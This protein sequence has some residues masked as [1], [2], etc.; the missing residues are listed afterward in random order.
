[1]KGSGA[2]RYSWSPAYNISSTTDPNVTLNPFHTTQYILTGYNSRNCYSTDTLN[3]LV[4]EDCGEMYV[5]NAFSPN[6]DGANDVLYVR[7]LCL[8]SLS[9][10]IFNRWGEK[11]F[12]TTD[13]KVG[14]DGTY[15]GEKLNTGIYVFR[16]EGKTYDGKGYSLKGNLTLLR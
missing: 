8:E 16:L 3:V 7:G 6:D 14:W 1:V 4:I 15:R 9:F 13:Q 2:F 5:P 12:E 11:I 10:I